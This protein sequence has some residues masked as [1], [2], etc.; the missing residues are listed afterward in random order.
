MIILHHYDLSPFAEKIRLVCGLKGLAWHSVIVPDT[1]P[2]PDYTA[3]TG[4]YRRVPSLQIGADVFCDTRLIVAEL[5]ARTPLPTV[6]PGT[7]PGLHH[8]IEAWAET[9]LFWPCARVVVGANVD[10]LP[11]DF[12]ADRAAMRGRPP[13]SA[14]QVRRA[15]EHAATELRM[16][17]RWVENLLGHGQP[18]VTGT[19]PGLADFALYHALW[20]LEQLPSRQLANFTTS[21]PVHAWMRRIA[22]LGHGRRTELGADAAL[23]VASATNPAPVAPAT[24]DAFPVGSRVSVEPAERT[25]APVIGTLVTCTDERVVVGREDP[26]TGRVHVHFPRLGYRVAPA[27]H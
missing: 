3:L 14:A 23:A 2:K 5:E 21:P 8:V 15:G 7:Q 6:C 1:L 22:A 12:H 16:Q 26:R 27:P 25:S 19:A 13:P 24:D 9:Q 17:I 11:A 18:F 10:A 20:F 4:G